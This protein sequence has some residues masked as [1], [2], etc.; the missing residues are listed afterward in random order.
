MSWSMTQ[1]EMGLFLKALAFAADMHGGQLKK[2]VET[3]PYIN[4]P[5]EVARLLASACREKDLPLLLAALLHDVL[6]KTAADPGEISSAFGKKVL[7]TVLEVTDDKSQPDHAR[8]KRQ[9]ETAKS[10]SRRAQ[11]IRL[12]DKICNIRDLVNHPVLWSRK[13]KIAYI[14][15][16][17]T[18][19]DELRGTDACLERIFKREHSS[20]L[21]ALQESP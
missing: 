20:A 6:E 5:I 3:H 2:G 19:A 4:H 17:K 12:A 1:R 16:A 18:L 21:R 10:L 8:K 14:E 15:R 9:I 13:K 11:K 7:D